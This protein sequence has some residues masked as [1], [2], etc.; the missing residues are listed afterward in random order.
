MPSSSMPVISAPGR[1]GATRSTSVS[2]A[3]TASIGA[4]TS[5]DCSSFM[6]ASPPAARGCPRRRPM[7][8]WPHSMSYAPMRAQHVARAHVAVQRVELGKVGAA[9]HDRVAGLAAVRGARAASRPVLGGEAGEARDDL[10]RDARLVAERDEHRLGLA[11][12]RAHAAAQRGRL[13][14][15]PAPGSRPAPSSRGRRPRGSPRR[16][17][18]ST[19]TTRSIAGSA[20]IARSACSS[21]GRPSSSASCLGAPKRAAAP[22]ARTSPAIIG[23]PRGSARW[24]PTGDRRRGRSAPPRARP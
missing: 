11:A 1:H 22:A 10:R 9:E 7:H 18:P 5:K 15:L 19:T 16:A 3:H 20:S 13:A 14:L 17:A 4:C 2:A 6:S 8:S 23:R 12:Q 21:S 24:P